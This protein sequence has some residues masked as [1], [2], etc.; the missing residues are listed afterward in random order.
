MTH[1]HR[2]SS[3]GHPCLT[4]TVGTLGPVG[5]HIREALH[6]SPAADNGAHAALILL[7]AQAPAPANGCEWRYFALNGDVP[8]LVLSAARDGVCHH[9]VVNLFDSSTRVALEVTLSG[10]TA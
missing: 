8:L 10:G 7:P 3:Q 9:F 1:I 4:L 2:A 5:S 6:Y